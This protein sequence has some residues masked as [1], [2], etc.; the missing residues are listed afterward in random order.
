MQRFQPVARY[1]D[2]L[3]RLDILI[4]LMKKSENE[5]KKHLKFI[6]IF[7]VEKKGKQKVYLNKSDITSGIRSSIVNKNVSKV[8]AKKSV[9]EEMVKR[10]KTLA[11]NSSIIMDGRDIGTVVFKNADLKIYLTASSYVRALRRK[12][13]LQRINEN[14][15]I[16]DLVKQ[17]NDRDT[18]DSSR[19]ISPL[20]K[21]HDAIVADTSNLSIYQVLNK[22][23]M[24][25][26]DELMGKN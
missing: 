2:L 14:V 21:S 6:N 23:C 19:K 12:K 9:R 16:N 24:F 25:L 4:S 22:I 5:L 7:F 1:V 18:Y 3:T 17:I 10:Q 20:I 26:P 8:S 11:L 15:K 13:D